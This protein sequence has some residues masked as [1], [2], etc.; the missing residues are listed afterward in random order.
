MFLYQVSICKVQNH[1]VVYTYVDILVAASAFLEIAIHS[2]IDCQ[3]VDRDKCPDGNGKVK[4]EIRQS[5]V[6]TRTA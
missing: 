1:C 4:I 3:N 6:A 5:V 2:F